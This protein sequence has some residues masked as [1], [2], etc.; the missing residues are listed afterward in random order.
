MIKRGSL[1]FSV[2]SAIAILACHSDDNG[3]GEPPDPPVNNYIVY[4]TGS[5]SKDNRGVSRVSLWENDNIN[6][7][8]KGHADG[9]YAEGSVRGNQVFVSGGDV[10]VAGYNDADSMDYWYLDSATY[11]KNGE[12]IT[13]TEPEI[14]AEAESIF[15]VGDDVYV[16]GNIFRTGW[17]RQYP[18]AVLWKNGEP[19]YLT[20]YN[21][22]MDDVWDL[23]SQAFSVCVS[24]DDVYVAGCQVTEYLQGYDATIWKNGEPQIIGDKIHSSVVFSVLVSGEDVYAA[25]LQYRL[26]HAGVWLPHATLWKNGEPQYLPEKRSDR[27]DTEDWFNPDISRGQSVFVSG[28]DVYVAGYGNSFASGSAGSGSYRALLW[29]NGEQTVIIDGTSGTDTMAYSVFVVND[30]VFV[31]GME[32][33]SA[34]SDN[35]R[36]RLWKNGVRQYLNTT[37]YRFSYALSVFVVESPPI[38]P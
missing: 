2:V 19:T 15:V 24:G 22:N 38:T 23:S 31:A 37:G 17:T 10:Y 21:T 34:G 7:I 16:A 1:L 27:P 30:D 35:Y 5:V 8:S 11:W 26:N 13:L 25:G 28:N 14:C 3:G 9:K 12:E 36:A 32:E 20:E 6:I 29:K 4:V 33:T 18:V